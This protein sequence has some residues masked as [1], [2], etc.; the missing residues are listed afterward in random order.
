MK[1][2]RNPP[3]AVMIRL[4]VD[5][6]SKKSGHR[7]H[8]LPEAAS[9]ESKGVQKIFLFQSDLSLTSNIYL[10]IL[11]LYVNGYHKGDYCP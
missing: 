1:A 7:L 5:G 11:R 4:H 6:V 3:N 8:C 10:V 2:R 9:T